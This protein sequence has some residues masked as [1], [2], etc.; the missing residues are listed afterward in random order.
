MCTTSWRHTSGWSCSDAF[1]VDDL[2][3][4]TCLIPMSS[5]SHMRLE[6]YS[7]I[8]YLTT[9]SEAV[10]IRSLNTPTHQSRSY[11]AWARHRSL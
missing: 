9:T 1:L 3:I 8:C 2:M 5:F 4:T 10:L 7:A 6:L 11:W